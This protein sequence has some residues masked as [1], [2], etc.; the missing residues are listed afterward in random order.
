M[1]SFWKPTYS[2]FDARFEG[3]EVTWCVALE[4]GYHKV[5]IM[6]TS[7]AISTDKGW[8]LWIDLFFED[9]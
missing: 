8:L 1:Q 7:V 4:L 3:S 2:D 6:V 5:S 9:P